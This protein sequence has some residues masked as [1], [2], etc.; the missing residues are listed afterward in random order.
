MSPTTLL[1]RILEGTDDG[2]AAVVLR[3]P[4]SPASKED[5]P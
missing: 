3:A 1:N 4:H 2:A 5:R